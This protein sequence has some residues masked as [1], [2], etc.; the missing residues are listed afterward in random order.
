MAGHRSASAHVRPGRR[1]RY[2]PRVIRRRRQVASGI[3]VVLVL[4]AVGLVVRAFG[5]DEAGVADGAAS[6]L[7]GGAGAVA[8]E[9][10]WPVASPTPTPM[11]VTTHGPGTFVTVSG[12]VAAPGRGTVKT[13]RLEVETGTDV[14]LVQFADHVMQTLN[15][16]RSWGH[17]GTMT[18]ARTSGK[19][20]IQV[21]LASPDT[22][23][24]MCR[25]LSTHGTESCTIGTKV[26]LTSYRWARGT[27]EFPSLD[28]YREYV[29]NHEVG[30]ALGHH[31]EVC[32]GKGKPAPVMQQQTI[33]VAPCVANGW[34]Y[35]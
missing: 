28:V 17:G 34:P 2:S 1:P 13:V 26:I 7:P 35:L 22:S 6:I 3:V 19:A 14:D 21:L 15:D 23:E 31:H 18:F 29:V 4:G 27:Q 25:P 10:P 11:T 33:K 20:D 8:P 9:V 32:P 24:R 12:G 30:H 16:P 5:S